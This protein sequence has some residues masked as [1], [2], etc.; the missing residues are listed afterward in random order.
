[1]THTTSSSSDSS[2]QSIDLFF[3]KDLPRLLPLG[4][5]VTLAAYHPCGLIALNKPTEILSHPNATD[6]FQKTLLKD[7]YSLKNECYCLRKHIAVPE[8]LTQQYALPVFIEKVFLLNRL[9][10]PTSGLILISLN[11]QVAEIIKEALSSQEVHKHYFGIVKGRPQKMSQSWV[12][13]LEEKRSGGKLRVHAGKALTAKTN[14]TCIQ[15]SGQGATQIS[16]LKLE[17][18]TGRTHQLRVQCALNKLPILGDKTY[19]DFPF[20]RL[21]KA[22]RL[23]LHSA[24]ISLSFKYNQQTIHFSAESPMPE[25]FEHMLSLVKVKPKS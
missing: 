12:N 22:K 25:A 16:L 1:M 18:L 6:D 2:N 13:K 14:M 3:Q 24:A 20:N 7:P 8:A 10:S 5:G 4:R 15:S 21:L 23:F 9:D 11:A 19:G 17:P